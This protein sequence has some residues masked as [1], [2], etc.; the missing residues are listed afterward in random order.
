[1]L[2]TNL[3]CLDNLNGI[4][5]FDTSNSLQTTS[6]VESS[7]KAQRK[8][9]ASLSSLDQRISALKKKYQ[10]RAET[11][12][13]R[14]GRSQTRHT[15]ND[16]SGLKPQKDSRPTREGCEHD[17]PLRHPSN[18]PNDRP[19]RLSPQN[20]QRDLDEETPVDAMTR[21]QQEAEHWEQSENDT[22]KRHRKALDHMI[23]AAEEV[24][25]HAKNNNLSRQE[26]IDAEN[27]LA[28]AVQAKNSR[29]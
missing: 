13:S 4:W 17:G 6:L 26:V 25:E 14:D 10:G 16:E 1:M 22:A 20:S 11:S 28:K 8:T 24:V 29:Y 3:R 21:S 15:K 2:G 18:E 5:G 23:Q 19:E 7:A 12:H 9:Q 27:E